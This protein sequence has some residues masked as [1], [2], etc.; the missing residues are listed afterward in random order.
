MNRFQPIPKFIPSAAGNVF[1]LTFSCSNPQSKLIFIPP[2]AEEANKSRH[3]LSALGRRLS[4]HGIQTTIVD[5]FGTGDSEGDLDQASLDIWHQDITH[6]INYLEPN[7]SCQLILGGLRLGATIAASYAYNYKPLTAINQL[8]Y[9]Q[10]IADGAT[11]MKQ[12]LRLKLAESI[13][14]GKDDG[15][16][17]SEIINSILQGNTHEISGYPLSK[18]LFEQ[19]SDLK[20]STFDLD[21]ETKIFDIN[22]NGIASVPLTKL[23]QQLVN[24]ELIVCQDSQF[25][26]C[27]EIVHC[28]NLIEVTVKSISTPNTRRAND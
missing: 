10:P 26:A 6:T 9:W 22:T 25:W 11:Y 1:T 3:I 12:F 16:T 7:N 5:L 14:Q 13:A 2:F 23:S 20:F 18:E 28:N 17:T 27:Q 24:A 19:I 15:I 4:Q 21:I 8:F